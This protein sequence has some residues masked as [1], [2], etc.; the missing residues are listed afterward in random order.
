MKDKVKAD[1]EFKL[2]HFI[3]EL[4]NDE[5]TMF[6]K[7]IESGE[8]LRRVLYYKALKDKFIAWEAKHKP[9]DPFNHDFEKVD[10]ETH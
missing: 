1:L 9:L 7:E 3:D 8:C 4:D 10:N 2:F 5:L 6:E